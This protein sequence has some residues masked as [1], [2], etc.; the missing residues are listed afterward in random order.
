MTKLVFNLPNE[1]LKNAT[2]FILRGQK[3]YPTKSG[4]PVLF[5]FMADSSNVALA[6]KQAKPFAGVGPCSWIYI[7]S[8]VDVPTLSSDESDK[9]EITEIAMTCTSKSLYKY[10]LYQPCMMREK[11][12]QMGL[13]HFSLENLHHY[14]KPSLLVF[15]DLLLHHSFHE[16]FSYAPLCIWPS[17]RYSSPFVPLQQLGKFVA[18]SG[19]KSLLL[20]CIPLVG[21]GLGYYLSLSIQGY[22]FILNG[23]AVDWKSSKQSTTAMSATEVEYIDASK[24]V[25]EAVWIR[26][27][28]SG[29]GIAP[30]INE[31]I[32]LFCDNLAA[33]HFANESGVQRG[34]RYYHRRYHYVRESIAL[35]E[36]RFLKVHTD[37]NLADPFTKALSKGK[38]TQHARSMGLRLASSF[39]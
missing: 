38:L 24:A 20:A 16:I 39:M 2:S 22:V 32:R 36:I 3:E 12:D 4:G 26:K 14:H 9:P 15:P 17:A 31:P 29:L 1:V 13:L 28:I 5:T 7:T 35:G 8:P 23:G 19:E 33:L 37:D 25:M 6:I 27:F 21:P 34:A 18:V 10:P 30:K 11:N